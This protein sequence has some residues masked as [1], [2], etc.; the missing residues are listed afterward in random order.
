MAVIKRKRRSESFNA[1]AGRQLSPDEIIEKA[2]LDG[3]KTEPLDL[4]SLASKLGIKVI[5]KPMDDQISG[6]LSL[7]NGAWEIVVN[8]L[9]HW[10]R[11]R[12]TLA[13][14]LGHF[15]LHRWKRQEFTDTVFFRNDEVSPM[16]AEANKFAAE[17]LMPE[18]EF[19]RHL[20]EVSAKVEDLAEYFGVSALAVRVRA[21]R[22]G[23]QGHGL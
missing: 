16:E 12:F 20:E 15:F 5:M 7:Q 3:V 8:S 1:V 14:E 18:A 10:R 23:Y 2:K 6:H 19:K 9:H 22:L 4:E 17:L 11:Q 13:H 21:K